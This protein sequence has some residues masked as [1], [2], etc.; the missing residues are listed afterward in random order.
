MRKLHLIAL[1]VVLSAA[2]TPSQG[3]LLT[4]MAASGAAKAAKAERVAA[5]AASLEKTGEAA[6]STGARAGQAMKSGVAAERLAADLERNL[7]GEAKSLGLQRGKDGRYLLTGGPATARL[8][9][10]RVGYSLAASPASVFKRAPNGSY[11]SLAQAALPTSPRA[12]EL[13]LVASGRES[14][15]P[16]MAP[17]LIDQ[18]FAAADQAVNDT[19]ATAFGEAVYDGRMAVDEARAQGQRTASGQLPSLSRAKVLAE[20]R[21]LLHDL[22]YPEVLVEARKVSVA[23]AGGLGGFSLRN[24][25]EVM[26][27][28][29]PSKPAILMIT[30][31][32]IQGAPNQPIRALIDL[33]QVLANISTAGL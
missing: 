10:A 6:A 9:H 20:T 19:I 18:L 27:I 26:V 8:L 23:R 16:A 29:R 11:V 3:G 31:F 5:A 17:E 1:A 32:P 30:L 12:V 25:A 14:H 28:E 22:A 15:P 21:E 4:R 33:D 13:V 7:A 2:I 24:V